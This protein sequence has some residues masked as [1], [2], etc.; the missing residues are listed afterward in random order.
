MPGCSPT[1]RLKRLLGAGCIALLANLAH[2]APTIAATLRVSWASGTEADLAGYRLRYGT[3][4]GQYVR[5]VDVGLVNS[6][7][8]NDLDRDQAYY[9]SVYAY[10]TAGNESDPSA[11]VS[12]RLPGSMA[13][14]PSLNAAFEL[15]THSIYALRGRSSIFVVYGTGFVPGATVDFG[16]G[17][18]A[19]PAILNPQGNLQMSRLVESDASMGPRTVT[20]SNPDGGVGSRSDT[21]TVVRSPDINADCRVDVVDLNAMARA[22]NEASGEASYTAASD[23]DGDDYIGPEDLA[24]FVQYYLRVFSG[25]P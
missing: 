16:A 15:G 6:C 7:E 4:P 10:D 11:E 24:I 25:C 14:V 12:A 20:V 23:L 3:A 5:T 13:P 2:A 18:D 17:I 8:L 19:G 9:I 1:D 21:V 22:W